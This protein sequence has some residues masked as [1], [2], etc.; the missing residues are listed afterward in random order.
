MTKHTALIPLDGS[1]FSDQIVPHIRRLLDPEDYVL[2]LLRVAE[3]VA[4]LIGTPPRPVSIAWTAAM[5]ELARDQEYAS[6]PIYASQAEASERA[7]LERE[8]LDHQHQ[9]AQA[10]YDVTAVVRFGDAAKEIVAFAEQ[11]GVDLVAMATHGRT[12]L[13]HLHLGSVAAEVLRSL[14]IPILLVRPSVGEADKS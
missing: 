8:L 10:G 1:P 14:T 13:Q 2:V 4:G 6:H 11:E 3:P 5:P 12:G 9:L 7:A